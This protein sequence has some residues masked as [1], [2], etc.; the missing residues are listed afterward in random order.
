[1]RMRARGRRESTQQLVREMHETL[2]KLVESNKSMGAH[3]HTLT[4]QMGALGE[5]L[6]ATEEAQDDHESRILRLEKKRG[7]R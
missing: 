4:A 5:R 1:M 2:S 7:G 3:L 6:V